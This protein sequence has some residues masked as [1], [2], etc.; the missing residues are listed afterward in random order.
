[1]GILDNL[2]RALRTAWIFL[3]HFYVFL[4][5]L[6]WL[7]MLRPLVYIKPSLYWKINSVI[8]TWT[9]ALPV[10]WMWTNGVTSKL[11]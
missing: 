2:A 4:S 3:S 8:C 7:L 9:L 1:M 10:D 11:G 5:T 6:I